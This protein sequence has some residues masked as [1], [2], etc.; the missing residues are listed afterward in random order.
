[1]TDFF[2]VSAKNDIDNNPIDIDNIVC[3]N[4]PTLLS[5]P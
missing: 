1:M 2:V 5:K 4:E 3:F